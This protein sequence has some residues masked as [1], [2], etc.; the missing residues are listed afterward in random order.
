ME[1]AKAGVCKG[2]L[3]DGAACE[4]AIHVSSE[5]WENLH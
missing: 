4:G 2:V 5:T 1:S 3:S